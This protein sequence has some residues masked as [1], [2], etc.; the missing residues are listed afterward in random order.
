M[1]QSFASA[2]TKPGVAAEEDD[3]GSE[4]DRD[5]DGDEDGADAGFAGLLSS[6]IQCAIMC[7]SARSVATGCRRS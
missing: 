3:A 1:T 2:P 5:G 6:S 4:E 7:S